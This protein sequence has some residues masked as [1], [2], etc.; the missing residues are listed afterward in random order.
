M[1]DGSMMERV[2]QAK[3]GRRGRRT[4]STEEIV[5]RVTT[6]I[7]EQRLPPGTKLG[8]EGLGEIFGVS[9]TKVRQALF[10]LAKHKLVALLP[11]RGAYVSQPSVREAREIFEARRVIEPALVDSFARH[12][13]KQDI[14]RLRVH[15]LS[16]RA[17][18]AANDAAGGT[19]LSGEF[20]VLIAEIAGNSV[21]AD[22]LRELI[23]RTS[24]IILLYKSSLPASCSAEEHLGLLTLIDQGNVAGAAAAM[25]HHLEHIENSLNFKEREPVQIDLRAALGFVRV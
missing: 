16:E 9:R 25:T 24:L 19:K 5:Q 13:A 18:I 11:S 8:E 20:H 21:L 17:A 15:V 1:V 22:V 12:A 4:T 14:E 7:T 2:V 10:Q 23:S 6:A 3:T